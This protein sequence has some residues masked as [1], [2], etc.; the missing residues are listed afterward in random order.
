MKKEVAPCPHFIKATHALSLRDY[1]T[2]YYDFYLKN[3]E[4]AKGAP[5]FRACTGYPMV[6]VTD[7]V[8]VNYVLSAPPNEMSRVPQEQQRRIWLKV[9]KE[10]IGTSYPPFV[11]VGE[12]HTQSRGTLNDIFR[13][14]AKTMVSTL[15]KCCD[16]AIHAEDHSKPFN[17]RLTMVYAAQKWAFEWLFAQQLTRETAL[18]ISEEFPLPVTDSHFA[19][20]LLQTITKKPNPDFIKHIKIARQAIEESV[21]FPE[22]QEYAKK[23]KLTLTDLAHNLL[24]TTVINVGSVSPF[25]L[26]PTLIHLK[27]Y[28]KIEKRFVEEQKNAPYVAW[29]SDSSPWLDCIYHEAIRC[30]AVKQTT[31]MPLQDT[32]IPA[33][34]GNEYLIKANEEILVLSPMANRDP[35][36]WENP[37]TFDPA[38]FEKNPALKHKIFP[39]GTTPTSQTPY[40]CAAADGMAETIFKIILCKFLRDYQWDFDPMPQFDF[41]AALYGNPMNVNVVNFRKREL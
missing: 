1:A 19:N 16:E 12:T 25:V 3:K 37:D 30:H 21:Y 27:T 18:L 24:V 20:W 17:L 33:G 35:A 31:R 41:N 10:M 4:K 22:Y 5:V 11:S 15:E 29:K 9:A 6:A 7:Y 13:V 23:N 36:I 34:D 14:R 40:K 28:P 2:K 39:F 26:Y 38:R 32:W 8:S